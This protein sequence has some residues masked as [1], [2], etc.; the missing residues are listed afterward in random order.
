MG[1]KFSANNIKQNHTLLVEILLT[2]SLIRV[3]LV[4]VSRLKTEKQNFKTK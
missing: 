2:P 1:L 3:D 4:V